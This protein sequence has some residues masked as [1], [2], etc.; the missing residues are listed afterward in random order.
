MVTRSGSRCKQNEL[1]ETNRRLS[2]L[3]GDRA[4]RCSID[5]DF[6]LSLPDRADRAERLFCCF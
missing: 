2:G 5:F 3:V 6:L 1:A 4:E